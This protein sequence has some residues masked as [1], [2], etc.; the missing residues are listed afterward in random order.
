MFFINNKFLLFILFVFLTSCT[1]VNSEKEQMA[2]EIK[3]VNVGNPLEVTIDD[4]VDS[5]TYVPLSTNEC[6]LGEVE[7]IKHDDGFYFIKDNK[8]LFVFKADG[9]FVSEISSKGIGPDEYLF[10]NS[11]CLDRKNKHV[12]VVSNVQNKMMRFT[13]NGNFVS[14]YAFTDKNI[15]LSEMTFLNNGNMVG[16]HPF[17]NAEIHRPYE[18]GLYTLSSEG[19]DSEEV[20]KGMDI[21]AGNVY[22]PYFCH[23]MALKAD[24]LYFL[25]A[26]KNK[27]YVYDGG[28]VAHSYSI[29]IPNI[30][31]ELSFFEEHSDMNCL[32]LMDAMNKEKIGKGV[33]AILSTDNY[34]L[35]SINSYHSLLWDGDTAV[36]LSYVFEPELNLYFDLVM[37]GGTTDERLGFFS[38]EFLMSQ[39]ERIA[40]IDDIELKRII[41]KLHEEDNPIIYRL[42]LKDGL[43]ESLS[44]RLKGI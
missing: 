34:I 24:S 27:V 1:G 8:G 31:P 19:L 16:Y 42:H 33:R 7:V 23:S 17:S 39:K 40:E 28:G 22:Y 9:A 30:A 5:V 37:S 20:F 25:S 12:C 43:V 4:L 21:S 35:L 11:F 6:L 2:D 41:D 44:N 10:M 29:N 3:I 38:A 18:Y 13:Y 36:L 32:D 26:F 14:A 15:Q